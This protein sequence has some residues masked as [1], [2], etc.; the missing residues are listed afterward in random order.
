MVYKYKT[1]TRKIRKTNKRRYLQNRK[2]RRM[3]GGFQDGG[4][5]DGGSQDDLAANKILDKKS[6]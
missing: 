2:S 3:Y 1:K 6:N 5:Q 4:F